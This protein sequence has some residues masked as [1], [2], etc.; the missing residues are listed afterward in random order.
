M[1]ITIPNIDIASTATATPIL[2]PVLGDAA[3]GV[4]AFVVASSEEVVA[5]FSS[6]ANLFIAP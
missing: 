3:F 4:V 5:V 6:A 2:S 1:V